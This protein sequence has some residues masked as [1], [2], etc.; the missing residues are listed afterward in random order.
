MQEK[1]VTRKP[2]WWR[3][4]PLRTF[5]SDAGSI[6]ARSR[7]FDVIYKIVLAR[8]WTSGNQEMIVRAEIDYLEL[9]RARLSFFEE[10]PFRS[11]PG[12]FIDQFRATY[13]SFVKNG[14]DSSC[15]PI[16]IEDGSGDLLNGGHRL[17]CCCAFNCEFPVAVYPRFFDEG[18]HGGST[19]RAYVKGEIAESVENRGVRA[20]LEYN[21]RSR[22][23]GV[24]YESG[25]D[26][27]NVIAG[28]ERSS[29]GV[30]W[31]W[32]R[33]DSVLFCVVTFPDGVPAEVASRQQTETLARDLFPPVP[34]PDWRER[35]KKKRFA[36]SV[37]KLKR[38]KYLLTLPFRRGRA[39]ERARRKIIDFECRA[40][41]YDRLADYVEQLVLT[42][43]D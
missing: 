15:A 41:A 32:R 43:E 4:E 8:A 9:Q 28:L 39:L 37:W 2:D 17:A 23:I 42:K 21:D 3:P 26:L 20:Y 38:L 16:P 24:P 30:V 12:D 27:E 29:G 22:I 19:F 10:D 33:R 5:V 31:H 35:A 14:F 6:F 7:R 11:T 13:A 34:D 40:T 25:E 1:P 18:E 36:C